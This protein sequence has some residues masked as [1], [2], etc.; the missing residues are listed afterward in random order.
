MIVLFA[1]VQN[2]SGQ[3]VA[4][5]NIVP[6]SNG[7]YC[8]PV[9]VAFTNASTGTGMLTYNWNFGV[10]P[11]IQAY[12]LN[13]EYFYFGAGTYTVTLI[14]SNNAGQQDTVQK[15]IVIHN[16]PFAEYTSSAT[17]VCAGSVVSFTDQSFVA[18]ATLSFS[19][20]F[21]DPGSSGNTLTDQNPSHQFNAPG[22]YVVS[23]VAVASTGCSDTAFHSITVTN[24]PPL[25]ACSDVSY[26]AGGN[27]QLS[28]SGAVSYQWSPN[29]GLSNT[30]SANPVA[31]PS[32][33]TTYT[34]TGF[35]AGGCVAYDTVIVNV[36]TA[37]SADAG[38]DQT[39]CSGNTAQLN[40]S[41]LNDYAWTPTTGLNNAGVA[42]P[43]ATPSTTQSYAVTGTDQNGCTVSDTVTIYVVAMAVANAGN[44]TAIC[45]GSSVSLHGAGGALY[46]WL[47]ANGLVDPTNPFTSCVP[48]Q[49]TTYTLVA[50]NGGDCA[51]SDEVVVTVKAVPNV[52]TGGNKTICAGD[53]VPLLA[54]GADAFTWSPAYGLSQTNTATPLALLGTN[55]EYTVT[56]TNNNGCYDTA[57]IAISVA[58]P[59]A[60]LQ[61]LPGANICRGEQIQLSAWGALSYEWTPADNLDNPFVPAPVAAPTSDVTYMVKGFN[62]CNYDSAFVT[63]DV[64]LFPDVDAGDDQ[65]VLPNS[66]VQLAAVGSGNFVWQPADVLSCSDC[67]APVA[68]VLTTTTFTV[69][70]H[71]PDGCSS[72]DEVVVHAV[73]S[74]VNV[75]IPNAFSPNGDNLNERFFIRA[76]GLRKLNFLRVFSRYGELVFETTDATDGWDGSYRGQKASP[77]V[78]VYT[79]QIAC[80]ETSPVVLTGNVTLIR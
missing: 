49:T 77:G 67:A 2:T 26:C 9:L 22:N 63:I 72:T 8:N 45:A 71:G 65:T 76:N 24:G 73:C 57:H 18:A 10:M 59:G 5:F 53:T 38:E 62:G 7:I 32:Q 27:A 14:V 47:P 60:H 69:T 23:M 28:A 64:N 70:N 25:S 68:T 36:I 37:G 41:G 29:V 74:D 52:F 15:Q 20:N 61:V 54:T 21:Q 16:T 1:C 12:D 44:D 50:S 78:Y 46:Q 6:N 40:A 48:S 17:S 30:A 31:S 19:W 43:I 39:V 13:P 79:A 4:D 58:E 42:N 66:S 56:G 80:G 75:F 55:S 34:V 3:V 35:D 11:G 51:T 33:T